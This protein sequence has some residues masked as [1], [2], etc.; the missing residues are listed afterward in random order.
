MSFEL[1]KGLFVLT[2]KQPGVAAARI[3]AM[4]L[5]S[6]ALWMLLSLISIITSLI[7]A[8][9]I[10]ASMNSPAVPPELKT[11]F[12]TIPGHDSPLLFA[13][14]RWVQAVMV[15]FVLFWVGKSLGGRGELGDVLAAMT[16]L[17]AVSF[18]VIFA[19]SFVGMVLPVLPGLALLVFIFWLIWA[20]IMMLDA[21]HG[22][23]NPFKSFGV[24][25]LS[26]FGVILGLSL[27]TGM[28]AGLF[29]GFGSMV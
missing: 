3:I 24:L 21:A 17:Q 7:L 15:I 28:I 8:G 9:V 1:I 12:G 18:V 2:L 5:P 6:Q 22:F 26:V 25:I 11:Y 29:S 4:H 19:I 13:L 14:L 23:D 20:V 27:F 10:Q 16:L